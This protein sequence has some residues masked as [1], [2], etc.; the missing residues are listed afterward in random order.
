MSADADHAAAYVEQQR[1][2]DLA[3]VTPFAGREW[4]LPHIVDSYRA[5]DWP[6]ERL[7]L[8]AVD[9]SGSEHFNAA[10]W[11]ALETAGCRSWASLQVVIEPPMNSAVPTPTWADSSYTRPDGN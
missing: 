4:A 1:G 7:H 5:L 2:Y 11:A 8:V 6:R 3:V 9:N 10:L